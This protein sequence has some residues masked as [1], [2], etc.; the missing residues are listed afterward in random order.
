M[1]DPDISS[2]APL[3]AGARIACFME[4]RRF[5]LVALTF[6]WMPAL[7]VGLWYLC[8]GLGISGWLANTISLTLLVATPLVCLGSGVALFFATDRSR[9]AGPLGVVNIVAGLLL[10]LLFAFIFVSVLALG[11]FGR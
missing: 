1:E 7:S 3:S 10:G 8:D 9:A 2:D 5:W 11:S 6:L 4:G